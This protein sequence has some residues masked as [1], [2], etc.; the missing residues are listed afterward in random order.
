LSIDK[1]RFRSNKKPVRLANI[2]APKKLNPV[3]VASRIVLLTG[4]LVTHA[5]IAAIQQTITRAG[6]CPKR[7]LKMINPRV[8]PE[9]KGY[10]KSAS[11][12]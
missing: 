8:V 6:L 12:A 4:V 11:P 7:I 9:K 5:F 3:I 1:R 2:I 10:D